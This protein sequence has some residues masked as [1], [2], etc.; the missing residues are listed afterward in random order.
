MPKKERRKRRKARQ[1]DD[2]E[3]EKLL[4]AP[5]NLREDIILSL[6]I[7]TGLRISDVSQILIENIDLEGGIIYIPEQEKTEQ[8]AFAPIPPLL[9]R[10]IKYH[11]GSLRRKKGY[12]FPSPYRKG[13]HLTGEQIR[14]IIVEIAKRAECKDVLPHDFRKTFINRSAAMGVPSSLTSFASGTAISTMQKHYLA[15]TI[16]QL[17][18]QIQKVWREREK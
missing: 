10:D 5:E 9:A 18:N 6:F 8:P 14:N 3:I 1:L 12:L 13:D 16:D 4:E 15:P 2:W 17:R 7:N 11:I